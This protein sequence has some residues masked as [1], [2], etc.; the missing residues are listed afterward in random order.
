MNRKTALLAVVLIYAVSFRL[1]VLNRPFD[2]DAEGSGC[3]N[4]V[5]A[6]SYLRFDWAQSRGMPILS[7]DPAHA[8]PIV[9]YPDHP[10]LLPLLIVPFYALFGVGAWQTRLP[11]AILTI[12]AIL[13]LYR[14]VARAANER[15][16]LLAAAV[17]AAMPMML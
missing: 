11:V 17:F 10:P 6:R 14:M 13:A 5:L 12:A 16:A 2:Y 4:G 8:T 1:L 7:L 3:L 9:F 15:I